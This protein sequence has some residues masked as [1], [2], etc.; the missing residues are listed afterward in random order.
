VFIIFSGGNGV[1]RPEP[2]KKV[3]IIPRQVPAGSIDSFYANQVGPPFVDLIYL[4][5]ILGMNENFR[6]FSNALHIHFPSHN[7]FCSKGFHVYSFR[8]QF[9]FIDIFFAKI[10]SDTKKQVTQLV[11]SG[12]QDFD[13]RGNDELVYADEILDGL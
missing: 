9:G 3:Y 10:C 1:G 2:R 6:V 5:F 13:P 8:N 11:E 4:G 12:Y 7:P